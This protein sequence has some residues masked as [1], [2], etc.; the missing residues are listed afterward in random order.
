MAKLLP[1]LLILVGL[2]GG[3]GAGLALRPAPEEPPPGEDHAEAPAV[4]EAG[5]PLHDYVRLNNQFI[6]PV[7]EDDEVAAL[8][9]MSLSLEVAPGMGEI[10]FAREPKLRDGF[11][12]VLFAHA[13]AGGF[14]GSF[15]E[16]VTLS[17]L[18]QAL[19]ETARTI[20]GPGVG[21][22][23]IMDLVRQDNRS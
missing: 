13:N 8:V 19:V 11:L 16:N 21:D 3:A 1:L 20:V 5:A 9:I 18:R 22:V 23:L 2:I 10:V 4:D 15:T 7:V 12:Q 6:V 14:R 17:S